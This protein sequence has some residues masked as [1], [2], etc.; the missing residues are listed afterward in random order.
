ML[1]RR[2]LVAALC[3]GRSASNALAPP[4]KQHSPHG[5]FAFVS[6]I[7]CWISLLCGLCFAQDQDTWPKT[8]DGR[9]I[10]D[11]KGVRVILPS[12][13]YDLNFISFNNSPY[14]KSISIKD[15]FRNPVEA[16]KFFN[17]SRMIDVSIGGAVAGPFL[18]MFPNSDFRS[19][20]M[21]IV[22]GESPRRL[23]QEQQR[24]IADQQSQVTSGRLRVNADG[25]AETRYEKMTRALYV[26]DPA[27]RAF[28]PALQCSLVLNYCSSSIALSS[29]VLVAIQFNTKIFG[30]SQWTTVSS[31]VHEALRETLPDI[32]K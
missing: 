3:L 20:S 31:H 9:T 22:I 7:L 23:Y 13:G 2:R 26:R 6:A 14:T 18:G 24:I 1:F 4:L 30:M 25:W 29:S 5:K 16:R 11:V 10:V 19:L 28:L 15:V 27:E 32:V 12:D 17:S 8:S 21:G